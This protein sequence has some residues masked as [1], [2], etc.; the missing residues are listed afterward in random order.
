M[1]SATQNGNGS[2][3][4]TIAG[5]H[6]FSA[7]LWS[8]GGAGENGGAGGG[9]GGGGGSYIAGTLSD[10]DLRNTNS[11][12]IQ[13]S[14]TTGNTTVN[15]PEP[16]YYITTYAGNS[17]GNGGAG[18]Y[19]F[20]NGFGVLTITTNSPGGEH[21]AIGTTGGGGGGSSG[22]TSAPGNAGTDGS[23]GVGGAGGVAVTGGG[24][25][26]AG[27]N[28]LAAGVAGSAPGG[29]GGGG[30]STQV[31]GAGGAGKITLTWTASTPVAITSTNTASVVEN[32]TAV[33]TVTATGTGPISFAIN[34]GAD[35]DFFSIG[36]S[37]GALVFTEGG[38]PDFENKLDANHDNV[39]VVSVQ[40]TGGII[41]ESTAEQIISVTVTN[42]VDV[43]PVITSNGGGAT[44][45][46]SVVEGNTAVTTV[47]ATADATVTYS[48]VAGNDGAKFTINSS[49][50]ALAFASAPDFEVPTDAN[51]DNAYLVT[52]KALT[53]AGNDTQLL[54]VTVTNNQAD[55]VTI[56]QNTRNPAM[57]G[58]H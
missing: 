21:G 46:V 3:N 39:Y 42:A 40:V 58:Q 52:V 44:G 22:G 33:K 26:G 15:L 36:E 16:G 6:G 30:G 9:R 27:G 12:E 54:T 48:I 38:T 7:G 53:A 31:G 50:G 34:G 32:T 28:A 25:G 47:V 29:G 10:D 37:S 24:A 20:N 45:S 13:L 2:Q 14:I 41:G 56:T 18:A 4:V 49:S 1:P 35:G 5:K 23:V 55:D 17:G 11:T 43:V 8:G 51:T 19:G 57:G